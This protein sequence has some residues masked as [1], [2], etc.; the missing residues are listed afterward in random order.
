M[1][2]ENSL[3]MQQDNIFYEFWFGFGEKMVFEKPTQFFFKNQCN[4]CEDNVEKKHTIQLCKCRLGYVWLDY[5]RLG[6]S[7]GNTNKKGF[8]QKNTPLGLFKYSVINK[9][10]NFSQSQK[11]KNKKLSSQKC[12]YVSYLLNIKDES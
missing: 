12:Q 11:N 7:K 8:N 1:L 4:K 2:V 9:A 10:Y 6:Q 5:V 3:I